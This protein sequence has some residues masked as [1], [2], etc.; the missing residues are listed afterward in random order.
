MIAQSSGDPP[1]EPQHAHS[2]RQ[3][4]PI[5]ATTQ[6][7]LVFIRHPEPQLKGCHSEPQLKECHM[8]TLYL[9]PQLKEHSNKSIFKAKL[10]SRPLGETSLS[11]GAKRLRTTLPLQ[12][13]LGGMNLA[14]RCH[15]F[16]CNCPHGCRLAGRPH[17]QAPRAPVL[18]DICSVFLVVQYSL[19]GV[20]PVQ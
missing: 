6:G 20:T 18:F 8:F 19:P 1:Y 13:S 10:S 7:M 14:T 12:V 2:H 5:Q 3:Y 17:R 16:A 9:E 15:M 4:S 11:P